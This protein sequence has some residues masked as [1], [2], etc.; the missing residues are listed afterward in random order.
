MVQKFKE[1]RRFVSMVSKFGLSKST[2]VFKIPLGK[3]I[4]S[5]PKTK[6]S[7]SSLNYFKKHLKTFTEIWKES[8][9][10]FK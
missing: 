3:L 8:A 2:I 1:K 9:S 5:Y 7:L 6:I 10:K 4:N